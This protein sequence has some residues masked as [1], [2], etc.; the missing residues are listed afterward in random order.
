MEFV[1]SIVIL[2]SLQKHYSE[3]RDIDTIS[4]V[5]GELDELKNIMVKNIGELVAKCYS[6]HHF[7]DK[8]VQKIIL[9][10][11]FNGII[12]LWTWISNTD[13]PNGVATI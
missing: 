4:R 3:S 10:V 9:L 2:Y 5:H 6:S 11:A 12:I 7:L 13:L 1:L 8:R